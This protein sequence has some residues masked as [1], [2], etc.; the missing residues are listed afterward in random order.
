MRKKPKFSIGD[1]VYNKVSRRGSYEP[2]IC[3]PYQ[4]LTIQKV[5]ASNETFQYTCDYDG[6]LFAESELLS[7]DEYIKM[8][9]EG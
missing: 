9:E 8:I 2:S 5:A 7:I 6:Y 3:Q 1:I 4:R